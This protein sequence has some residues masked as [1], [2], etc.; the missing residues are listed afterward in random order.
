MCYVGICLGL[1]SG[2]TDLLWTEEGQEQVEAG[3]KGGSRSRRRRRQINEEQPS[4]RGVLGDNEREEKE[5][6]KERK[7]MEGENYQDKKEKHK[8]S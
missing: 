3:E 1:V 8:E 5:G 6:G 2:V 7:C 4:R